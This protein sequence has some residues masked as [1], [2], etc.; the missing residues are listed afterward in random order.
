MSSLLILLFSSSVITSLESMKSWKISFEAIIV[1]FVSSKFSLYFIVSPLSQELHLTTNISS[2]AS[3]KLFS[4]K[5]VNK[6][7]SSLYI[8]FAS[9]TSFCISVNFFFYQSKGA[10]QSFG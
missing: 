3:N 7:L 6:C 5:D 8:C 10:K 4:T 1:F 2:Q 9:L